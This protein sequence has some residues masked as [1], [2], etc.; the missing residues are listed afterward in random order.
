MLN[1]F[2]FRCVVCVVLMLFP[3]MVR[4][5][6]DGVNI[7]LQ[8]DILQT[9][10]EQQLREQIQANRDV[11][12][13]N[14]EVAEAEGVSAV[15]VDEQKSLCFA[16][17][18]VVLVGE[19]HDVFQFA[20]Q[21][22]LNQMGFYAG[23]CL[24]VNAINRIMMLAQNEIIQHGYTTTRILVEPQDLSTG[25]LVLT[26]VVGYLNKVEVNQSQVDKTYAYRV[27]RVQNE[28]PSRADGILNLRDLEQGLENLKRVPTAEADIQIV[29]VA[30]VPNESVA[31]VQ[32]RQLW[33]PYRLS[34]GIDDSGSVATGKYQGNVMFAADNPLGLSDVF[35]VSYGHSLGNVPDVQGI[36][37]DLKKGGA[38]HHA[39]HYSVPWGNWLGAINYSAYRYHQVVAGLNQP[40]DYHGRSYAA[41]LGVQR[42]LHR[43][44]RGKTYFGVK[45]WT[46]KTQSY[47]DDA[48]IMVQRRKTA[49][50]QAELWHKHYWGKAVL[51]MKIA[52]KRGT[53]MNRA[54]SAPEEAFGEGTARMKVW[55]FAGDVHLP[56]Y[57]GKQL[58]AYDAS[59]QMQW[60]ATPLT[61]QDR[62]AIGGRYTVRGFDGEL[63]LAAER[64]GFWRN[65]L[66]WHFKQGQQLYLG[67]DVGRVSGQTA[68]WL[69]GQTLAG[70]T[71]GVRG[72]VKL[73]G[74]WF[75]HFFVS[76]AL[77]KPEHFKTKRVVTG[78]QLNY[79]F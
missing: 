12:L 33:L 31:V 41:D 21:S 46:R 51:Q 34:V 57:L 4:A 15:S 77:M 24:D 37:R 23:Q 16:I 36:S 11:R 17:R 26:L 3:A 19:H 71:L 55:T 78:F 76:R 69:L 56:F 59:L 5:A 66:A 60:N 67:L 14:G 79:A 9:Q 62:F 64:G 58:F 28:F 20:L 75:Y 6:S 44:G 25:K 30:D 1:G 39:W 38:Y 72:Q 52:Y 8:Q 7:G 49:G 43:D 18:E 74:D 61:P 29:P 13:M 35:Y 22:A 32:W 65:D 45:W 40:Y 70:A 2:L 53:G 63:S 68:K 73:A 10:R 42:L 47:I 27:A 54:L 48:E 50:W